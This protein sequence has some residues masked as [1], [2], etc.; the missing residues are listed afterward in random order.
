MH[1]MH[2]SRAV[3]I[4]STIAMSHAYPCCVRDFVFVVFVLGIDQ[5]YEE[6]TTCTQLYMAT[7]AVCL[8]VTSKT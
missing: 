2:I 8:L 3:P 4:D 6:C 7:D 5:E 1:I